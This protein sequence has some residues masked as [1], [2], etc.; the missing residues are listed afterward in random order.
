MTN[1]QKNEFCMS[2]T[3]WLKKGRFEKTLTS[4]MSTVYIYPSCRKKFC[5]HFKLHN[6]FGIL[7]LIETGRIKS[8]FSHLW[9]NFLPKKSYNEKNIRLKM[10]A[11]I[12]LTRWRNNIITNFVLSK[13]LTLNRQKYQNTFKHIIYYI[14][15]YQT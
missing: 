12:F 5:G 3:V 7:T 11:K 14:S 4:M 8:Q 9:F 10:S 13:F 1:A 2:H 6:F 15:L